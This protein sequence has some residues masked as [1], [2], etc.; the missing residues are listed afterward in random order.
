MIFPFI[1]QRE[2]AQPLVRSKDWTAPFADMPEHLIALDGSIGAS[3]DSR[4]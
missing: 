4:L 3:I 1:I 2:A